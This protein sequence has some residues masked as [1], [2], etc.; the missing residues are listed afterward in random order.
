GSGCG[1][2]LELIW[3]C[4]RQPP[5]NRRIGPF[6]LS[7]QPR[8]S[9]FLWVGLGMEYLCRL[10]FFMQKAHQRWR[11]WACFLLFAA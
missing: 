10:A 6:E 8:T 2:W 4:G 9:A 11:R 5:Q 1:G 7:L 3:R